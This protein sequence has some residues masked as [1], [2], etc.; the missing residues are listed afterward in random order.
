MRTTLDLDDWLVNALLERSPG[1]S[2]T[3]AIERAIRTYLES[4]AISR[5]IGLAGNFE[6]EDLSSELRAADRHT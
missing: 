5:L 2:K 1:A 3:E 4:D 6:I